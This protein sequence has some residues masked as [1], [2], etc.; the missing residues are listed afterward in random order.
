[1]ADAEI[2]I[3][4]KTDT[5]GVQSLKQAYREA[6]LEVQKL[7]N[8]KVIDQD[9]LNKAILKA[10]ELKDRMNDVN[11][12]VA[13]LTAG[14][15]FEALG[16]QL[17]DIG[18]KVA[19]L[20]FEGANESAQRLVK[21]TKTITL[22]E[23]V[24]GVK[25][26]GSTFINLGK[27][28]LTNPL[29][30]IAGAIALAVAG[31]VKLLDKMGIL[32]KIGE[33]VGWV[34]EKIGEFIEY[35]ADTAAAVWDAVF[36]SSLVAEKQAQQQAAANDKLLEKLKSKTE[37]VTKG[38]DREIAEAKAAGENTDKIEK[39][40]LM[41][42]LKTAE[43]EFKM[44]QERFKNKAYLAGLDEEELANQRKLYN[45]SLEAYK[46]AKS[47]LK[48]FN[49]TQKKE[50]EDALKKDEEA[51]KAA[52]DKARAAA[53]QYAADRLAAERQFQD[54][55]L[56][57]LPEGL[58]KE[59]AI[60]NEKYKRLIEDTQKNEK[61]LASEK[62]RIIAE[63]AIQ[64]QTEENKLKEDDNKKKL[65]KELQFQEDLAGVT[66]VLNQTKK[67]ILK[68]Q[69][70]DEI[71]ALDKKLADETYSIEQYNKIKEQL[72]INYRNDQAA[73]DKEFNDRETAARLELNATNLEGKLAQLEYEKQ[74]ELENKE[75]TE[76]EKL[77]IEKK[78]AEQKDALRKEETQK[79]I[80]AANA[81][82][83]V[84]KMGIDS[85]QAI[86]D[87]F[88]AN[89]L[90]KL[91]KGSKAEEEAARKQF[92]INKTLQLS[93][94]V[95]TGIQT[96]LSAYA[97]GMNNP[98]PLLGPA[99]AAVYAGIAGVMSAANIA[100]IASA[101]FG[102]GGAKPTTTAPT[103]AQPTA[104]P[105]ATPQINM[106]GQGNQLNNVTGQKSAE[107]QTLNVNA[108]VSVTE[109]TATQNKVNVIE[110]KAVL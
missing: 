32:K 97:N 101:K 89:K 90:S 25:D 104:S 9:A 40:K 107:A 86:S 69:Y 53:K 73:I 26:L 50:K 68:E 36:G 106:F 12:Q 91:E 30:L 77:L 110:N 18:G 39:K 23:A 93:S 81:D 33:A 20:D 70:D 95:I 108:T 72:E 79:K 44:Y 100:K 14:S 85:I 76:S 47:D 80:D 27:A 63:Y 64:Q 13:V 75:L 11:E 103:A 109:I 84:A 31:V 35:I 7:A 43:V 56:A 102:G 5:S 65:E 99:T 4:V 82:L 98:V 83:G 10:A 29:F 57:N 24:K 38:Y 15:K 71:K 41:T 45:E 17:G 87:A 52:N 92:N 51:Q 88:F 61:L 105:A 94:A 67:D 49:N 60:S 78:Y 2:N 55:R 21:L 54:L 62:K 19:S 34:F 74:L 48:V 42:I 3:K 8:A 46:Q 1:M 37:A 58:E 16:N 96:V 6:N 66:R 28:L 22:G 59:L